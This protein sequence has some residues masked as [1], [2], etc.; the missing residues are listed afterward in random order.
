MNEFYADLQVEKDESESKV[1]AFF[2]QNKEEGKKEDKNAKLRSELE[3]NF[4]PATKTDDE[5][6]E[7]LKV[8]K[9]KN[10]LEHMNEQVFD[11]LFDRMKER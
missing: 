6:K 1:P 7:L 3:M 2:R 11:F 10:A 4:D 8:S 9:E 5:L